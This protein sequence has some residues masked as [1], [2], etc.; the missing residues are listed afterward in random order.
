[1]WVGQ[2]WLIFLAKIPTLNCNGVKGDHDVK[3]RIVTTSS[4]VSAK[5]VIFGFI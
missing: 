3:G 4:L 2:K 5:T 1:M